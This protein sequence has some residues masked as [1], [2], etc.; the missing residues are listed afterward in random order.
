M[1]IVVTPRPTHRLTDFHNMHTQFILHAR[2][3]KK[4]TI[5]VGTATY[6]WTVPHLATDYKTQTTKILKHAPH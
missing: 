4:H 6:T 1:V 2:T 5:G 3:L